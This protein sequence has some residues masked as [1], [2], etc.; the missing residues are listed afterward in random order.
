MN[1]SDCSTNHGRFEA[2]V[3]IFV[4]PTQKAQVIESL[5]KLE[6]IEEVYDVKGEFDIVSIVSASSLEEF[7]NVLQKKIMKIK[8]VK[9]TITS[10]VLKAHRRPKSSLSNIHMS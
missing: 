10:I 2:S 8:G 3:N 4:D 1:T 5:S 9:S 6:N 7:R